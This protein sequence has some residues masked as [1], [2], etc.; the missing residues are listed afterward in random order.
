M[1]RHGLQVLSRLLQE[2]LPIHLD[3]DVLGEIMANLG[4]SERPRFDPLGPFY[5]KARKAPGW[6]W[7]CHD[8]PENRRGLLELYQ[9]RDKLAGQVQEVL[10]G[11]PGLS[12]KTIHEGSQP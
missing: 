6:S 3:D 7:G 1:K 12:V 4:L 9:L 5:Y 2:L 11:P 8:T 10:Y